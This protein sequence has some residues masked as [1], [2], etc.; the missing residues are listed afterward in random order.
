MSGGGGKTG[1]TNQTVTIPPDVLARYNQVNA[2]A[3][4][5]AA[6]P[7]QAYSSDPNSFVAPINSQQQTG[8]ANINA[9]ANEAQP[10]IGAATNN[11]AGLAAASD[12]SKFAAGVSNYMNPFLNNTVQATVNQL[13]NVNQQQQQ[14]QKGDYISQGAFGG[15]RAGV[16]MSSLINQQNLA[17]GQTVADLENTGFQNAAQ[18]YFTGLNTS[19][20]LNQQLANLGSQ[21]QSAALE[22]ANAQVGAGTLQQQTSQAGL[23]ALYQQYLQQKAYPF[24]TAQFQ[25]NIAEGTGALSGNTTT[26]TQPTSFFGGLLK[27]GGRVGRYSGGLVREANGGVVEGFDSGGLAGGNYSDEILSQLFGGSADAGAYGAGNS[28][29]GTKGWVPTSQPSNFRL[30]TPNGPAPS[31]SSG[32]GLKSLD[33]TVKTGEDLFSDG[34]KAYDT[35]QNIIYPGIYHRGGRTGLAAG[36]MPYENDNSWVPDNSANQPTG[37]SVPKPPDSSSSGGLVD[38]LKAGGD[39]AKIVGMFKRGGR[40][41]F[42]DGGVADDSF[43]DWAYGDA[44]PGSDF[45]KKIVPSIAPQNSSF[46][47]PA[48]LTKPA[49]DFNDLAYG[50]VPPGS[51]PLERAHASGAP[52]PTDPRQLREPVAPDFNDQ[53]FGNV[54]P[55]SNF[56]PKPG[57]AIPRTDAS[58]LAAA[59]AGGEN[60]DTSLQ[61]TSTPDDPF[62]R[63]LVNL[64]IKY[65]NTYFDPKSGKIAEIPAPAAPPV[66]PT[67]LAAANTPSPEAASGIVSAAPPAMGG[68]GDGRTVNP[69]PPRAAPP[70]VQPVASVAPAAA[71]AGPGPQAPDAA[72]IF[73]HNALTHEGLTVNPNDPNGGTLAGFNLGQYQSV[74]PRIRSFADVRPA[75]VQAVQ[76]QWFGSV[77]GGDVA[78]QFGPKFAAAYADLSMLGQNRA[79]SALKAS[80]G[81]P[82]K[83]FDIMQANL[84]ATPDKQGAKGA[85][86]KR[87]QDGRQLAMGNGPVNEVPTATASNEPVLGAGRGAIG[88]AG[89]PAGGQQPVPAMASGLGSATVTPASYA[90]AKPQGLGSRIADLLEGD[91]KAEKPGLLLPILKGLG[92]M[93]SSNSRYLGS[94]VLQGVGAGAGAYTDRQK[95]MAGINLSNAQTLNQLATV[96]PN[97]IINDGK[98]NWVQTADGGMVPLG[99]FIT[100]PGMASAFGPKV[101]EQLRNAGISLQKNGEDPNTFNFK[102]GG[103]DWRTPPAPTGST[104]DPAVGPYVEK[105]LNTQKG[106]PM[107]VGDSMREYT[108]KA[109]ELASAAR[110]AVSNRPNVNEQSEVV[111]QALAQGN[112]GSYQNWYAQ[113]VLQPLKTLARKAGVDV[114]GAS[115]ADT[116]KILLGKFSTLNG[117]ANTPEDQHALAAF[118][119]FASNSPNLEM[120]PEAAAAI[121]SMLMYQNQQSIDRNNFYG[122]YAQ[123]THGGLKFADQAMQ[124]HFGSNSDQS[125]LRQVFLGAQS[126]PEIAQ[127]FQRANAGE[128]Q[129][130]NQANIALKY[131]LGDKFVEQHPHLSRYFVK[132]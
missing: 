66:A 79:Q 15:D 41:G 55:G 111:S 35:A 8:I 12:P 51:L 22:G 127:F 6:T 32:N 87:V 47:R 128:F 105:E 17:L 74:N 100:S 62:G 25:S 114:S 29:P 116:Q 28:S 46:V 110:E 33:D 77:G 95:Q 24:Q 108:E 27:R 130:E 101:D 16:G 97:S 68:L 99:Q 113:N 73:R 90:A 61:P 76:N 120:T 83:F 36:G 52:T 91:T 93:A 20:G 109:P 115:D 4:Q 59:L 23:S 119:A 21:G 7:Y 50:N 42:D 40:A 125:A 81:D 11:T 45:H 106:N 58:G 103:Q 34:R 39:I 122:D 80:G 85:W 72:A 10:A 19:A 86:L 96:V 94:A 64:G 57:P 5:T 48:A 56:P 31:S 14:Q 37:L 126:N 70:P 92:A 2:T 129:N 107:A 123:A 3:A 102:G 124:A 84:A 63:G 117:A 44:P 88:P 18:N 89:A 98:S 43:N 71:I 60:G 9:G 13:Q 30:N 121:T 65:A 132:A 82:N 78:K 54:L 53:A 1:T 67:G 26:T 75:D 49:D 118:Q 38:L 131:F 69:V 112:M 104:S